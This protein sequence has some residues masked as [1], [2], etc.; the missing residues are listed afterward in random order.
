MPQDLLLG[1][2][3]VPVE[4]APAGHRPDVGGHVPALGQQIGRAQRLRHRHPRGQDLRGVGTLL[5]GR[6]VAVD[7]AQQAGRVEVLRLGG[8]DVG[9][10]VDGDVE[11]DV[12][13]VLAEHPG[14]PALHDVCDLEGERRVVGHHRGVGRGQQQRV[15]VGM[16]Q[17]LAGQ[18]GAPGCRTEYEAAG[19]LVGGR[20]EPVAGALEAEH[21]IE[22][23]E[24]DH[25]FVVRGV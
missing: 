2:D 8:L 5:A 21:R 20:P 14:Q 23:V 11:V 18:G 1:R 7:A 12:L 25:R 4:F 6:A 10:V 13:R 19:H 16:L 9:L 17:P 15:A 3:A 22:D 24:R